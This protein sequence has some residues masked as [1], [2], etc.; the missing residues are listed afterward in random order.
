MQIRIVRLSLLPEDR[1]IAMPYPK[2]WAETWLPGIWKFSDMTSFKI[3]MQ[4]S[5][6]SIFYNDNQ[7]EH[8]MRK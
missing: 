4:N 6:A 7:L 1:N 2:E 3:D 5:M 8:V